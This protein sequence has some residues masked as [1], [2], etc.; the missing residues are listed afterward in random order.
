MADL[1]FED[2]NN[3]KKTYSVFA[4]DELTAANHGDTLFTLPAG[5][6]VKAITAVAVD[7]TASEGAVTGIAAG[8]YYP[9]G[10][11]VA[12]DVDLVLGAAEK[13]IVEYIETELT[14]GQYT[15]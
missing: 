13:I 3:Q 6:Y 10:A 1:R 4:S 15:D 8:N 12:A 5:S 9:T 2:K 11:T 14:N 7:N